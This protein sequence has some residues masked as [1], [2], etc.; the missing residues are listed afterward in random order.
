MDSSKLSSVFEN[1][2]LMTLI[3]SV[4]TMSAGIIKSI[5]D[6]IAKINY[7]SIILKIVGIKYHTVIINEFLTQYEKG[8]TMSNLEERDNKIL[9]QSILY[10][11]MNDDITTDI[12]CNLESSMNVI[13]RSEISFKEL[14]KS[15]FLNLR[16][17]SEIKYRNFYITYDNNITGGPPVKKSTVLTIRSKLDIKQINDFIR[18][19]YIEYV[20]ECFTKDI[21]KRY[22]Y[23]QIEPKSD[24]MISKFNKYQINIRTSFDN[25]FLPEKNKIIELLDNLKDGK[26]HKIGLFLHGVPGCGKT[27]LIRAIAKYMD[28]HIIM[29]KMSLMKSDAQ[30]M[31][32]FHGQHISGYVNNDPSSGTQHWHIGSNNCI[33]VMEDIDAECKV[34]HRRDENTPIVDN[35]LIDILSI[36]SDSDSLDNKVKK[37]K[38]WSNI[39]LSGILNAL[40]GIIEFDGAIIIMTSNHPEKIDKAVIRPGRVTMNIEMKNM[41]AR[42]ATKMINNYYNCNIVDSILVDY[43]FTPAWLESMLQQSNNLKELMESIKKINVN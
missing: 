9:V 4:S 13:G 5:I 21:N 2:L 34:F 38:K 35:T 20:K 26:L 32:V 41:T 33:Y 18:E 24:T 17:M 6:Y 11:I 30:I 39:T 43:T 1:V 27:T 15:K 14:R 7:W 28:R 40:D 3:T 36:D 16:P 10:C 29:P 22:L 31:D 8:S 19:C 37:L 42:E 25:V 12:K 23:Q